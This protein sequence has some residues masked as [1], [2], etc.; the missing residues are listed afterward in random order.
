M[1]RRF[2]QLL[3]KILEPSQS[4]S[5][6]SSRSTPK[7]YDVKGQSSTSVTDVLLTHHTL[8]EKNQDVRH[9]GLKLSIADLVV[10]LESVDGFLDDSSLSKLDIA[11]R[12]LS[13]A[14]TNLSE[15]HSMSSSQKLSEDLAR[16]IDAALKKARVMVSSRGFSSKPEYDEAASHLCDGLRIAIEN[17]RVQSIDHHPSSS[18]EAM[19][20]ARAISGKVAGALSIAE[21]MLDGIPVPGLKAAIGGLL[22]VLGAINK[23][24]DNEHDLSQLVDHLHR[25][26]EIVTK[27]MESSKC[28]PDQSL[29]KG[30][31]H[32]MEDIEQIT[33]DAIKIKEQNFGS[34]FL[35]RTDN[36][37]ALAGLSVAVDRAVDR[38]QVSSTMDVKEG[39]GEI[40]GGVTSVREDLGKVKDDMGAIGMGVGRIESMLEAT[41]VC[42]CEEAAL[43]AI[44]PRVESACYDS[45]SQM[46]SSFCLG[47]TRVEILRKIEEWALDPN[48]CPIF[49]LC[50]MAGTGKSTIART[51]A[52]RFD[53]CHYLGASFF[54]SRDED[55]RRTTNLLFPTIAYQLARYDSSLRELIVGAASPDVCTAMMKTQLDK[56]IV[57]PLQRAGPQSNPL[58]IV[59]DAL[60]ECTKESEITE[61]LVL[62][63]PA[64]RAIQNT[65]QIKL[66]LTSRP[67]V[68][69][70]SEFK[71]PDMEAVSSFS[72]LHDIEKSLVRADIGRYIE[73]HL[74]RI[75][76]R[77]LP[78]HAVWPTSEDRGAL[79]DMADGLFIFAA[80]TVAYI[81]DTKHRQPKQRLRKILSTAEHS[82]V[83][84]SFKHLDAL[85]R[86][87]FMA[88]LP[89]HDNDDDEDV[90]ETMGRIR[91]IIG[92]V[93]L[94]LYP[95]SSRSLEMLLEWE[96]DTVETTLG[97]FHSVL[98]ISPDPTPIRVFHK[99]FP[100]FLTDKRRS[101]D[102]YIDPTQQHTRLALLCLTHMNR[103]LQRDMCGVGN[104]LVLE[105]AD[106]EVILRTRVQEHLLYA[107]RYWAAHLKEA[108]WT[109]EL[110]DALKIFCEYKIMYWLEILCLDGKLRSAI[111]ALD[112]ARRCSRD[113]WSSKMLANCYRYMLYFQNTISLGPSHIYQSTLPFIPRR[114]L[115]T[116]PWT[117]ELNNSPRVVMTDSHDTWDR[118]LFTLTAH[119]RDIRAVAY[120]PDGESI[121]TGSADRTVIVWDARTGVQIHSL[122]SHFGSVLSVDFSPDGNLIASG[123]SD[124]SVRIW[125]TVTGTQIHTLKGHSNAVRAVSFSPLGVIVAS[126]SSDKSIILWD[127]GTGSL[128]RTLSGHSHWVWS[129]AFSPDGAQ[130]VSCSQDSTIIIWDTMAGTVVSRLRGNESGSGVYSVAFSPDGNRLA[131]A[132]EQVILWDY[133]S[134]S[135]LTKL[136]ESTR[137]ALCVAFSPDGC[138][139]VT[140]WD[141]DE[142][143]AWD[144]ADGSEIGRLNS[145][146]SLVGSIAVSPDGSRIVTDSY[147]STAAVWDMSSGWD[148]RGGNNESVEKIH[149]RAVRCIVFSSDG[150]MLASGGD[151]TTIAIWDIN[152]HTLT[153]ILKGHR[154]AV[155]NLAFSPNGTTMAS[156]SDDGNIIVWNVHSGELIKTMRVPPEVRHLVFS[157]DG[158]RLFAAYAIFAT[159]YK[160]FTTEIPDVE[161]GQTSSP[162]TDVSSRRSARRLP[163][164]E[165][166]LAKD[167]DS[168]WVVK[169]YQNHTVARLCHLPQHDITA[170]ASF[171]L[172]LAFGTSRGTMFFLEF[173][174]ETLS[175]AS[176][177]KRTL[178]LTLEFD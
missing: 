101:G 49:W 174:P 100:D 58:V 171:G 55:D 96:E 51:V 175:S 106:M 25:L 134:R 176:M 150:N 144:I 4:P 114:N 164:V 6:S 93:V 26:V 162:M 120:S 5:S 112:S 45:A 52:R 129:I 161:E 40:Q 116:S 76:K 89:D 17:H 81:G 31:K 33:V 18:P 75:A 11:I 14:L 36:A 82:Q 94:L 141:S 109:N 143:V 154:T 123:S 153:R 77:F 74:Q 59:L 41:R 9:E 8:T 163:S 104:W 50:G 119:S 37:S 68:H 110:G 43:N 44:H 85:Y 73:H 117:R 156:S 168:Q 60:D 157:P 97:P 42:G 108:I 63:A 172:T 67:E 121:A 128:I 131:S 30:V 169:R 92:T 160:L 69:I 88:S 145:Q 48:S 34:K 132:S 15:S 12:A 113:E 91:D 79:I 102:L 53:E 22:E 84:V 13:E 103:S 20:K 10:Y 158:L 35:G 62:L 148:C 87:I 38:F 167:K 146:S 139:I 16:G 151:D 173:P 107:C 133:K 32:L 136:E 19:K 99:S 149:T 140:G 7:T 66:F 56:L 98:S 65:V 61:M 1:R 177:E 165:T 125:R 86:Q 64:I 118:I 124:K 83:S 28:Q 72:I 29:M 78:Q 47:D 90:Q 135:I 23:L 39:V 70:S 155:T 80:V 126:G 57:E 130:I 111:L 46:S 24:V 159:R 137:R 21:K 95:L 54:F 178:D 166:Y 105:I 122:E 127:S 152:H 71:E 115:S 170:S 3:D 2:G 27:P 147:G 142:I 138:F